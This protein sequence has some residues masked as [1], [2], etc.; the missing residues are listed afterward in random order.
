[1]KKIGIFVILLLCWTTSLYA[2]SVSTRSIFTQNGSTTTLDNSSDLVVNGIFYANNDM[3]IGK[4]LSV[5][6]ALTVSNFSAVNA[7]LN[8]GGTTGPIQLN[9]VQEAL[10]TSTGLSVNDDVTANGH[11]WAGGI[12]SDAPLSCLLTL[13]ANQSTNL[14]AGN[15]IDFGAPISTDF[16]YNTTTNSLSLTGGNTYLLEASLYVVTINSAGSAVY[17]WYNLTTGSFIYPQAWGLVRDYA[18]ATGINSQSIAK[19]YFTPSADCNVEL[20]WGTT[21][22]ISSAN[23][24]YSYAYV[25]CKKRRK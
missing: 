1:M 22:K 10:V 2:A 7:A 20:R 23:F 13:D 5:I 11:L 15:N 3:T 19:T 25:E 17:G 18:S 14:S 16:T 21:N 4:N 12:M 9:L 24:A 8:F 6:G